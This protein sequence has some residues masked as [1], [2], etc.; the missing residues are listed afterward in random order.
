MYYMAK[1]PVALAGEQRELPKVE[2]K[3]V[4]ETTPQFRNFHIG[5]VYCNGADKGI[6]I[7]GLPEMHIKDIVLENMVLQAKNGIEVQEATDIRFNNIKIISQE[8][9]PVIDI[10]QSDKLLFDNISYKEGA[11]LLFRV[12]GNRN[13]NITIKRTDASKAKKKIGFELGAKQESVTIK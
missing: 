1:D 11:A 2:M 3:V 7:R 10:V 6:F 13:G 5:N 9:N 8:T 12:S 4:D